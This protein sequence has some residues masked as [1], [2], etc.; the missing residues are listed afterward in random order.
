MPRTE[1]VREAILC[2]KL[3]VL[4]TVAR[5]TRIHESDEVCTRA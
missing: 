5:D 3:E 2:S 4:W 1:Q